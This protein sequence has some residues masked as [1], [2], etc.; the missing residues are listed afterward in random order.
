MSVDVNDFNQSTVRAQRGD[1]ISF[2]PITLPA[3]VANVG[4]EISIHIN[5]CDGLWMPE[6]YDAALNLP[7]W[8]PT[9]PVDSTNTALISPAATPWFFPS[10]TRQNSGPAYNQPPVIGANLTDNFDRSIQDSTGGIAVAQVVSA[11]IF[12]LKI[13]STSNVPMLF[14]LSTLLSGNYSGVNPYS[15]FGVTGQGSMLRSIS[16]PISA[17]FFKLIVPAA[18]WSYTDDTLYQFDDRPLLL[19]SLGYSQQ[20]VGYSQNQSTSADV[21]L[22]S[23][24]GIAYGS[25]GYAT[26]QLNTLDQMQLDNMGF[27]RA[28][29]IR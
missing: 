29:S 10:L 7:P 4:R 28:G 6:F 2:W 13:N 14:G 15:P 17:L 19:S 24:S 3:T 22:N 1:A 21:S 20:S 11:P 26:P 9:P 27:K 8:V 18:V 25:G 23:P 5:P 16:G 12:S